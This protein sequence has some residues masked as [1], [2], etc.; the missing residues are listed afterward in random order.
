MYRRLWVMLGKEILQLSRDIPILLILVWAFSGAIYIAGHAMSIEVNNYPIAIYDLDS[1]EASRELIYKFQKPHFKI[2][3]FLKRDK[4]IS[5]ILDQGRASLVVIIPPGF[6]SQLNDAQASFQIISDGTQ[7][8]TALL[9]I[10][11][12][13][14]ITQNY[15]MQ[16]LQNRPEIIAMQQSAQGVASIQG[17]PRVEFNSNLETA[18]FASLLEMFNIITMVSMLLTAAALVREKLYGTLD[19]LMVTPLT[20]LELFIAKIVPTVLVVVSLSVVSLMIMV[21]QVFGT[22]IRGNMFLFY[23]VTIL[24]SFSVSTIGMLVAVFARNIAQA[25]MLLFMILMPMLFLSGAMTPPESMSATMELASLLS[26]MRYF[27]DFGYQVL[28]K[29]NGIQ[30]VWVDILGIVIFG[31]LLF[32]ISLWR[33]KKMLA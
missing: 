20:P 23:G 4:D 30:Y 27:I 3:T 2:V 11:Y 5:N 18:W 28:F 22:P 16:L 19:Q 6:S 9:A 26:P 25:M 13:S 32:S 10:S 31:V 24:Y 15:N 12:I 8:R 1:S 29:G 7:S 33:F 17:R 14:V 21:H